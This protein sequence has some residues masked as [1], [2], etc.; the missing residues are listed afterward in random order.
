M[1]ITCVCTCKPPEEE[2]FA[3]GSQASFYS[4]E[5]KAVWMWRKLK[6]KAIAGS[7]RV[8]DNEL[9]PNLKDY[10][11]YFGVHLNGEHILTVKD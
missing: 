10:N 3:D 1:V 9:L 2:T 6:A 4:D 11:L 7:Q 8:R 5:T